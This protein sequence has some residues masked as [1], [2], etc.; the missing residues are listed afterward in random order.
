MASSDVYLTSLVDEYAV[1]VVVNQDVLTAYSEDTVREK[2]GR[3][4]VHFT[5]HPWGLEVNFWGA[6]EERVKARALGF[7]DEL[8]IQQ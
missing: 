4:R 2:A 8:G 6:N 7:L 5:S 1:Q 3:H